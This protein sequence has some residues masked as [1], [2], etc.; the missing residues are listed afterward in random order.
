MICSQIFTL[1]LNLWPKI[2]L[3]YAVNWIIGEKILECFWFFFIEFKLLMFHNNTVKISEIEQVEIADNLHQNYPSFRFLHDL[4]PF[5]G[6][7]WKF[8]GFFP[9]KPLNI[10]KLLVHR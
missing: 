8:S 6:V 3:T 9:P 10:I 4:Q 5:Y 7:K 1:K 2:G